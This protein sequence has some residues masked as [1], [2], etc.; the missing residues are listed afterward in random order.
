MLNVLLASQT[1]DLG[2]FIEGIGP[3]G[4]GIVS[5]TP[6]AAVSMFNKVMSGVIGLLTVIAAL[7]FI[8]QFIIGALTLLTSGGEKAGNEKAQKQMTTGVIGLVI[9]VSAIFLIN[10]IGSLIGLDILNPGAFVLNFWK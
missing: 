3:L 2:T 9:V 8:F 7:F 4:T 1:K 10:F 6:N 5:N